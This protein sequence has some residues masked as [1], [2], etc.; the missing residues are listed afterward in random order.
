MLTD[1]ISTKQP[2]DCPLHHVSTNLPLPTKEAQPSSPPIE[3]HLAMP[4]SCL[5]P[6]LSDLQA[7]ASRHAIREL[8]LRP[9]GR[10][11]ERK[12]PSCITAIKGKYL[13][14]LA[15]LFL[16]NHFTQT[17][18]FTWNNKKTLDTGDFAGIHATTNCSDGMVL[19]TRA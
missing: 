13:I 17:S 18:Y 15:K 3:T 11:K 16:G 6:P 7:V 9:H 14:F 10:R 12:I 5:T 1:P 19:E 2:I 8:Q 4:T